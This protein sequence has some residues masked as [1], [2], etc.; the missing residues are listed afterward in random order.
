MAEQKLSAEA[1]AESQT[2]HRDEV[3]TAVPVSAPASSHRLL[4]DAVP[5]H[6]LVTATNGHRAVA[7]RKYVIR[8]GI[9]PWLMVD[10]AGRRLLH[11]KV[12][13]TGEILLNYKESEENL[14]KLKALVNGLLCAVTGDAPPP[15]V[16]VVWTVDEPVFV[17]C[18]WGWRLR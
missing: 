15:G 2:M 13:A 14:A 9:G 6:A 4:G 11:I 7:L 16:S 17:C 12:Y 8:R 5:E 18:E 10:S 1:R 3:V